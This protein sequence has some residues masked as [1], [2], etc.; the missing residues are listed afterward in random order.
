MKKLLIRK[1][2]FIPLL[3]CLWLPN[4]NFAQ[5][6]QVQ[7]SITGKITDNKGNTL[8]GV[9][10]TVKNTKIAVNTDF[11]GK[12]KLTIPSN[13]TS[14]T[15]VFTY[16]GFAEKTELLNNRTEINVVL[17]EETNKLN[18]V[19]VI[20]Y[21]AIK[22]GNVTGAI[23]SV[24]KESLETR[25]TTNAAEA[26]QGLVAGVNVQKSGGVAGAAVSVKI[27]GVNTFGNTEPLYIIDGFQG[28][29]SSVNPTNIESI[30]VLKDGAAAAIYGSVAA[31]GVIIVTTKGWSKRR[32][33]S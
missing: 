26:L 5:D 9:N 28:S 24:K 31:N 25:A 17:Q 12:Y 13:I 1:L 16:L 30:E 8:P 27:R 22:K 4:I 11:D 21:G 19:V 18:E 29:I 6:N 10:I 32:Y 33:K 7:K 23:A 20:G 15:L 3:L 2:N 14:P